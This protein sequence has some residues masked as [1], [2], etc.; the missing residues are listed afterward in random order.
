[1]RQLSYFNPW[2]ELLNCVCLKVRAK[3]SMFVICAGGIPAY[4]LY[5]APAGGLSTYE[6]PRPLPTEGV[7]SPTESRPFQPR[8]FRYQMEG[9]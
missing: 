5:N 3:W 1:M 6:N 8:R 2:L 7:Q 4:P 9:H